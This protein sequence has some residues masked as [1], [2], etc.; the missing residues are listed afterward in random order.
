ML[1]SSKE[2]PDIHKCYQIGANSYIVKP[3]NFES[4]SDAI[5]SVGYYWLLLN[6]PKT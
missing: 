2:D 3:V 6:Q 4:F 5:K 1:T